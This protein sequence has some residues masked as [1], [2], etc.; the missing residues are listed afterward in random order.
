MAKFWKT[1]VMGALIA[2]PLW[3]GSI[4]APLPST[5]RGEW[6]LNCI[7]GKDEFASNCEAVKSTPGWRIEIATGDS[8]LF[9]AVAATACPSIGEQKSWWRDEIAGLSA[10]RRRATLNQALEQMRR[11]VRQQCPSAPSNTPSLDGVPD[12][13]VHGDP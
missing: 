13:A 6:A 7:A 10:T 12:V 1:L 5:S 3:N 11:S 2:L 9:L 8:Q 4:A